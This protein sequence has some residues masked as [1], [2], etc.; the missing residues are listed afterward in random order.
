MNISNIAVI[1]SGISGV[2]AAYLL[3]RKYHVTLFEKNPAL[4]GHTCTHVIDRGIDAG[5]GI[6]MGFI[7]CN[8]RNYPHFLKLLNQWQVAVQKSSM[9]FSYED[10]NQSLYYGS[11]FPDGLFASFHA[12]WSPHFYKMI[13][14][15]IRFNKTVPQFLK[16]ST[17]HSQTLGEFLKS[18]N[19]SEYFKN[20]YLLA[21]A[22]AI[23]SCPDTEIENY[24]A[25]NFFEFFQNHGLIS[26]FNK[27]QWHTIAGGS[28]AYL[29]A[30]SKNFSGKI[31]L[32]S[33]VQSIVRRH[34]QIEIKLK[35]K[36]YFFD[37]VVIATHADEALS[38][39]SDPS[40]DEKKY[41][42]A[43]R[44]SQNK[45]VLHKDERVMPRDSKV[46]SSW[47]YQ[48]QKDTQNRLTMTYWM[49]RLQNLK[50][51]QNYFVSL[52]PLQLDD[53]KILEVKNFTHPI[54]DSQSV[55]SQIQIQKNNGLNRT[56]YA[57]AYLGNGFHEDGV[58]SAIAVAAKL[59]VNF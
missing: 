31:F 24:P 48:R 55:A 35:E 9:S 53:S 49:N 29:K 11:K 40:P 14:E 51:N 23:W 45:T 21:T 15:I 16:D 36:S 58:N 32:S 1:G 47:N 54:Y 56:F 12:R 44:Y 27:P 7:V 34:D 26:F 10:L 38:L 13:L 30:F 2:T 52:N 4:G 25:K 17:R 59:G 33:P 22:A 18:Q 28:H 42:G 3:S 8:D 5:L 6:D 50:T 46:W 37:Q 20:H 19:Y 57:G 41:L 39:L 43:W